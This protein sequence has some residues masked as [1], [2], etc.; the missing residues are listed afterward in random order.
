MQLRTIIHER[1]LASVYHSRMNR[2]YLRNLHSTIT[3]WDRL[4]NYRIDRAVSR[5]DRESQDGI[6]KIDEYE[7][8]GK[9]HLGSRLTRCSSTVK[10]APAHSR[11]QDVKPVKNQIRNSFFARPLSSRLSV[12]MYQLLENVDLLAPARNCFQVIICQSVG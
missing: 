12:L 3:E 6:Y 11:Q 9:K 2:K 7:L 10:A 8:G 5:K 1:G 4:R